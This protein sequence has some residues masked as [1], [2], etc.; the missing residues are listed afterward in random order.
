[1]FSGLAADMTIAGGIAENVL[2]VPITAVQGAADTGI[3]YVI[4]ADGSQEERR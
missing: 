4:A 1:M 2:I 3:V